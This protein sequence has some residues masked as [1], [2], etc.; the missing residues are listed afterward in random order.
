MTSDY[1][2]LFYRE[3]QVTIPVKSRSL[4]LHAL[5]TS[6]PLLPWFC[7][8]SLGKSLGNEVHVGEEQTLFVV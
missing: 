7:L 8:K 3:V 6:G 5:E 4:I 2:Y 1:Y